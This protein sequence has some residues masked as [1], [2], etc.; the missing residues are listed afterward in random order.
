MQTFKEGE[1]YKER[2]SSCWSIRQIQE[3]ENMKIKG[4][5]SAIDIIR[6]A[7]KADL[8]IVSLF[9]L[10]ILLGIWSIFLDS[11]SFFD[12][13]DG[14]K[15]TV[16]IIIAGIYVI[17]LISMKWWDPFDEKL[18]RAR[19]HVQNRL[20][21]R[22]GNRASFIAI[23]EEVNEKYTDDFLKQLIDKNPAIFGTVQVKRSG[24][25]MPGIKLVEEE[26]DALNDT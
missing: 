4:V 22:K 16:I 11:I 2:D 19:L 24:Q 7:S 20:E 18:K 9:L 8:I 21:Q 6:D 10:P 25:W 23:R 17:G 3:N 5:R 12:Q 13:H 1:N 14:W 15:F 26:L